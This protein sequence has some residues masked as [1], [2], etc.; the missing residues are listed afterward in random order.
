MCVNGEIRNY[1]LKFHYLMFYMFHNLL[2]YVLI[3]KQIFFINMISLKLAYYI[4][5]QTND[6]ANFISLSFFSLKISIKFF[7]IQ[8][9]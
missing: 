5:V 4:Y 2:V 8:F 9:T 1:C 7:R 6:S 3:T